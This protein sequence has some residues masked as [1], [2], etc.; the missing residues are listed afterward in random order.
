MDY[1]ELTVK[2]VTKHNK[3]AVDMPWLYSINEHRQKYYITGWAEGYE[4]PEFIEL[5]ISP[6]RCVRYYLP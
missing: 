6:F 4:L 5:Q 2:E 3:A 1:R